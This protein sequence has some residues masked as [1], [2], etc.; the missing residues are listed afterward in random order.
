MAVTG[1]HADAGVSHGP[2]DD[3]VVVGAGFAG[4]S[5][6]HRLRDECGQS[7]NLVGKADERGRQATQPDLGIVE[8]MAVPIADPDVDRREITDAAA[9]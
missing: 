4:L 7:V 2:D 9:D 1:S 8:V 3:A 6:L 5:H